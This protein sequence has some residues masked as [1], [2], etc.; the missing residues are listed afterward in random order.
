MSDNVSL[1]IRIMNIFDIVRKFLDYFVGRN[2]CFLKNSRRRNILLTDKHLHD[3][4]Y[5]SNNPFPAFRYIYE[6]MQFIGCL[7]SDL[8]EINSTTSA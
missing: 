2:Y 7:K 4:L 6:E 5:L 8:N 1:I 3:I